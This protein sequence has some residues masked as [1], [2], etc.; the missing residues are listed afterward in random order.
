MGYEPTFGG[1]RQGSWSDMIKADILDLKSR[2]DAIEQRL[3]Q[4]GVGA[5]GEGS[6][7][8]EGT[9]IQ[10]TP[11]EGEPAL[12]EFG[13][14]GATEEPP[15]PEG[16][17][18]AIMEDGNGGDGDGDGTDFTKGYMSL[19]MAAV[20]AR[21]YFSLLSEMGLDPN[22]A[23]MVRQLE[24]T[25]MAVQKTVTTIRMAMMAINMIQDEDPMGWAMLA[26]SGGFMASSLFYASRV[27][28]GGVV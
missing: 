22:Q 6:Q 11:A 28:G 19:R 12:P 4:L 9:T 14:E 18:G 27:Q 15:Y 17:M 10:G 13:K 24:D 20:A 25:M 7:G 26:V 5:T 8:G 1:S 23:R 3:D 2:L 16:R 21:G